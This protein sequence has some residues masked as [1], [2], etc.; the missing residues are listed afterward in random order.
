[1]NWG[2]LSL[3]VTLEGVKVKIQEDPTL[4]KSQVSLHCLVRT[5]KCE[6]RGFLLELQSPIPRA[7]N[8]SNTVPT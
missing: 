6:C 4:S 3:Q 2:N 8:G 5:L 1:M 7:Q